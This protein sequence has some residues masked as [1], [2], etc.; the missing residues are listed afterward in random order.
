MAGVQSSVTRR[1]VLAGG[2]A[3]LGSSVSSAA[4]QSTG[5]TFVL[6]HGAW[7]GGW[8]WRH[9]ADMLE[10]Q[11]HKVFSPTMT[12]L[13]ERSNQLVKGIDV[14]THIVDIENLIAWES[15]SNIVLVGHSYGGTVINGVAE[16]MADKIDSIVFLDAFVPENGERIFEKSPPAARDAAALAIS[17]GDLSFKAP[18]A[19]AF[20]V[21]GDDA[22]WVDS[23]TTPQPLATFAEAAVYTGARDRI[24]RK[25]FIRASLHNS[26]TFDANLAKARADA[27]WATHEI[28]SG[29]DVMVVQPQELAKLLL[30]V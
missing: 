22:A 21:T 14:S 2:V 15:L 11:G 1:G 16:H 6:V 10:Q 9:V 26:P 29:H 3:G 13:G 12:G 4:G 20:G 7:H 27:S 23:K 5:K 8:C 17:R 24:L 25:T 28:V 30:S 18:P 19:S